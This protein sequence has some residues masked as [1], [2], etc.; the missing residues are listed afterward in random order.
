PERL[1]QMQPRFLTGESIALE[2][3]DDDRRQALAR[4]LTSPKNPWFAKCYV[5]RIW[6]AMMGWG[7]YAGVN[8]LGA[9]AEP[10]RH[11]DVL[12]LLAKEWIAGGYDMRWLFRTIALTQAYQRPHEA[13]PSS[14]QP[15]IAVCPVRLRPEQVF[16]ALQKVLG[17]DE[18]D[19]K[20]PAPAAN[21]APA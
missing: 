20:I 1:I 2:A 3:S 12:D 9:T 14:E 8:D 5:N 16:E 19:K 10:E 15:T 21:S 6:T 7:F 18:N 4:F 17:F 11:R 13:A